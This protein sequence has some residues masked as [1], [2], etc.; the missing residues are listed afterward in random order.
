MPRD[1]SD[2]LRQ[3]ME[4]F[5]AGHIVEARAL[6]LDLVRVNPQ[7][8]AGWMFLCYTLDDPQQKL[9]CLRQVL[10][11][12]P[13]N[14]EAQIRLGQVEAGIP[15]SAKEAPGS[16]EGASGREVRKEGG[17]AGPV[18]PIPSIPIQKPLPGQL[19]GTSGAN[20]S[21]KPSTAHVSPF[22]VD[23]SHAGDPVAELQ[24]SVKPIV[25]ENVEP[26]SVVPAGA[27]VPPAKKPAADLPPVAKKSSWGWTCGA[28][29]FFLAAIGIGVG[30]WAYSTGNIPADWFGLPQT[31]GPDQT[32]EVGPGEVW[33]MPPQWTLT[34]TPTRTRTPTNTETPPPQ[35]TPTLAPP[36]PDVLAGL[37]KIE[38]QVADIRGLDWN[39]ELP[40]FV[41]TRDQA[42]AIL[43]ELY[44]ESGYGA[45][46][47]NENR[48]LTA[49]GLIRPGFD[50]ERYETESLSEAVLGFYVPSRD[51]VYV[52]ESSLGIKNKMVFAHEFDHAL[53][54]FHFPAAGVLEQDS[55][56]LQDSQRCEAVRALVE[57]D[58]TIAANQWYS[59]YSTA[60]ERL[61]L[62]QE[63]TTT[64]SAGAQYN[65]PFLW[66]EAVFPY[67][68]GTQFVNTIR[69]SGSW[70]RVNGAYQN[71]PLSTEQ[72]IHPE[73]YLA[74][75]RPSAL[76][77]PDLSTVLGGAWEPIWT[78][79]LGEFMTYLVLGYSV[80]SATDYP[81]EE[82]DGLRTDAKIAAA[83]WDGDRLVAYYNESR[84][85]TLLVVEWAWDTPQDWQEFS[86]D[87]MQYLENRFNAARIERPGADCW[88]LA[89][90]TTC[91][92]QAAN[93]TLWILA[94]DLLT[95]ESVR[96]AYGSYP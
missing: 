43:Q 6:L 54:D 15:R 95:I 50:M 7:L 68:F 42:Q 53:V 89:R 45:T 40:I 3:A 61:A 59:T 92:F 1:P 35:V 60:E 39:A 87:L 56:C 22:T 93:K 34:Q 24:R 76:K 77:K 85:Q 57:G 74:G 66:P 51:V 12:N 4:F 48:V 10:T 75:E 63:P 71:L 26:A 86:A 82:L 80:D 2:V 94:P 21:T 67:Q 52:I 96:A 13:N 41:I 46:A 49:L 16:G 44:V 58:A 29:L 55:A 91:M 64:A 20:P 32:P 18:F 90:D 83:G 78:D 65:P 11:I 73:K 14:E 8:E 37:Q 69:Q 9:D 38:N 36:A 19:P 30:I 5:I 31:S 70:A 28:I 23:I 27:P 84:N 17:H 33:T 88:T 47:R 62:T 72:I 25:G 79:T 81:P